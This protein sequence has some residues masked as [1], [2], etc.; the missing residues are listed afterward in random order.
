MVAKL[1]GY[2]VTGLQSYRVTGLQGYIIAWSRAGVSG[3]A[4]LCRRPAA[5]GCN[6]Q[7]GSTCSRASRNDPV[8]RLV[9]RAHSRAPLQSERGCVE[10]QPLQVTTLQ[11]RAHWFRKSKR[12]ITGFKM[13]GFAKSGLAAHHPISGPVDQL[14]GGNAGRAEQS[15]RELRIAQNCGRAFDPVK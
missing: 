4:R 6:S 14:W 12:S 13:S 8:L 1:Q 11:D 5:A 3:G 9:L 15:K 10:D 7:D 2:K